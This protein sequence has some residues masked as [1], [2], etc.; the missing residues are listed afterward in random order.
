MTTGSLAAI[1]G[2]RIAHLIECDGPGGA[3]RM[4]AELA[5]EFANSGC[6]GV[7]FLPENGED[8]IRGE[9]KSSDLT[10]EYFRH[11]RAFSPKLA[12]D[13]GDAF[14]R[15][16][17]DIAHSH[18]FVMAVYGSWGAHRAKI[19]HLSTMH[20]GRYYADKWV[21]RLAL[22]AA[23]GSSGGVVAV[24]AE[25][26]EH[27]HRDLY[28]PRE[29]VPV[30]LNGVRERPLPVRTIREELELKPTDRLL[31]A[32]G[33]L[34]PVKG[35]RHLLAAAALLSKSHPTVHVALA[36]R[37]ECEAALLDQARALGIADR[38]HILGFRADIATLLAGAD[39]FVLPSL[40]EGLPLALL[41][42]M[43]AARTIVASDV[44]QIGAVLSGDAGK[45]V[46]PGDEQALAFAIDGLLRDPVA[47]RALGAAAARRAAEEYSL[48]RSV[49]RYADI[50]AR[51]LK[52]TAN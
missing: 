1:R 51:L 10:V 13:L 37:G 29:R 27:L 43:F 35:H 21:R 2:A 17:I 44:G 12:R 16:R 28:I 19:P 5:T 47:A 3:E 48:S 23:V 15:L 20:G 41:E 36:G 31:L 24:S 14:K 46:K 40:S 38:L 39:I 30:I 22:R 18:E 45:L 7:V 52:R 8:W 32:V 25:L 49:A 50:Y 9:L 6:P 11:E 4:L 34:Y 33:N 26:A 42:A